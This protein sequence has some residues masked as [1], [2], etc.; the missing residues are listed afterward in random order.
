VDAKMDEASN[1]SMQ[2]PALHAAADAQ[3][4]KAEQD[5]ERYERKAG[6]GPSSS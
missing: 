2:Q 1:Y 6:C 3:R 5:V 4:Q